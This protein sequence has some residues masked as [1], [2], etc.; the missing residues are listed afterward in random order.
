MKRKGFEKLVLKILRHNV[1]LLLSV[2][3]LLLSCSRSGDMGN[4]VIARTDKYVVTADSVTQDGY[5][6]RAVS[7]QEI[8]SNYRPRLVEPE[9]RDSLSLRLAFNGRDNELLPGKQHRIPLKADTVSIVAGTTQPAVV[10]AR[11]SQPKID[12]VTLRVDM[13]AQIDSLQ[14]QGYFT[15]ATGDTIYSESFNGV[16]VAVNDAWNAVDFRTLTERS[17]LKLH[18][19]HIPGIYELKLNV[20]TAVQS[21]RSKGRWVAG[22]LPQG[23][24]RVKTGANLIDALYNMATVTIYNYKVNNHYVKSGMSV[25]DATYP[26][27]LSLASLDPQGAM[28]SLRQLVDGGRIAHNRHGELW[29]VIVDDISWASA[30]WEVYVVTGDKQWLE[31][32]HGVV[33]ESVAQDYETNYDQYQGLM[34]GGSWYALNGSLYYPSWMQ[35]THIYESMSLTVNAQYARAFEIL[36][37]MSDELGIESEYASLAVDMRDAINEHFWNERKGYY[38]QYTYLPAYPIQS[39]CVD[40]LGQALCVLWNIANDDRAENLIMRTPLAPYGITVTSPHYSSPGMLTQ[41]EVS[42]PIIQAFWNIAAAKVGNEHS[43]RRGLG[44]LY[45]LP[46]LYCSFKS[47]CNAYTGETQDPGE[48]SLG[49]AAANVAMLLRVYAGITYLPNGMELNPFIPVFLTGTKRITGLRYRNAVL[50]IVIE[51]TGNDIQSIKLDDVLSHDNFVPATLTGHHTVHIVMS[52]NNHALQEI[53]VS[54]S[55]FSLPPTPVLTW[56]NGVARIQNYDGDMSYRRVINGELAS[57][58]SDTT[59]VTRIDN[60]G[61][62]V[63]AILAV[64]RYSMGYVSN[65]YYYVPVSKIFHLGSWAPDDRHLSPDTPVESGRGRNVRLL[66][67]A[68]VDEP[69]TYMLDVRY[70]NGNGAISSSGTCAARRVIVNDHHQG[71]LVMPAQGLDEWRR[72]AMTNMMRVDLL[73]GAN[74]IEL[75]C[76]PTVGNDVPVLLHYLRLIK[77]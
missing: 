21:V 58:V 77:K 50:D 18:P 40:N 57:T 69:G 31:Y 73:P 49:A 32:A 12:R 65:P 66:V 54:D 45:R 39:P 33:N 47:W 75:R 19:T 22:T 10:V 60:D 16:W 2:M 20:K 72:T 26:I 37:D 28:N 27:I 67:T 76:D 5:V 43:L 17:D 68:I 48:G 6:A 7:P 8:V 41:S 63:R 36:N 30:A 70:A 25:N 46:A 64:G 74:A 38:S 24:P 4:D 59:Y 51:G 14:S 52:N 35:L 71:T 11:M 61:F 62:G 3:L 56:S 29:P 9:S 34:H 13:R 44:A 53:T 1:V 42:F 15:T 55:S 23:Y